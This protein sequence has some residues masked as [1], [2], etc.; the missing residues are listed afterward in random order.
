MP[1]TDEETRQAIS[2]GLRNAFAVMAMHALVQRATAFP[3]HTEAQLSAR[4]FAIADAMLKAS[5]PVPG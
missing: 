1:H 4:A 5:G 2:Y 3:D